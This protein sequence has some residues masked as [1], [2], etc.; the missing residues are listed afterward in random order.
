MNDGKSAVEEFGKLCAET[1]IA[2]KLFA[3]LFE[4]DQSQLELYSSIAP[5][6]FGDLNN[7]LHQYVILQFAKL[8]DPA[9]TGRHYNLTSNY[10]L[11]EIAWPE[12]VRLRL[13]NANSRLM[14]FRKYIEGARSKRIAH[15]DLDAQL[16]RNRRGRRGRW[17]RQ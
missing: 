8:T 17:A 10:I 12:D 1:V 5:Y 16:G 14:S 13:A 6:C 4:V 9:K 11:E 2:Y 15:T 7:I 3:S